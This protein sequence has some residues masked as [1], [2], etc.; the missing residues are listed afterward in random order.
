MDSRPGFHT[1]ARGMCLRFKPGQARAPPK[2]L[3]HFPL[4]LRQTPILPRPP[5][6]CVVTPA[7]PS[8]HLPPRCPSPAGG[9]TLAPS[10]P[11][12]ECATLLFAQGLRR[13]LCGSTLPS[14]GVLSAPRLLGS[15]CVVWIIGM[16]TH[17]RGHLHPSCADSRTQLNLHWQVPITGTKS[18]P[19]PTL[20]EGAPPTAQPEFWENVASHSGTGSS[21]PTPGENVKTMATKKKSKIRAHTAGFLPGP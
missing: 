18:A 13:S 4:P 3:G 10:F 11:R 6:L 9:S 19:G 21:T 8:A 20:P 2:A 7:H 17:P 1:A 14:P 15:G 5:E 12:Q 16:P